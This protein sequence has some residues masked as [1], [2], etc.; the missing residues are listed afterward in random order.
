MHSPFKNTD[1]AHVEAVLCRA[2]PLVT[3]SVS[4]LCVKHSDCS[5]KLAYAQCCLSLY[6]TYV[7]LLHMMCYAC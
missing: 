6:I 1:E 3:L 7:I 4:N 2:S 5:R